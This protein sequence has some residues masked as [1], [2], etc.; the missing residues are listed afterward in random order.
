MTSRLS[1]RLL[2]TP[3]LPAPAFLVLMLLATVLTSAQLA[4]RTPI[5]AVALP[6]LEPRQ[7]LE[8]GSDFIPNHGQSDPL[9]RFDLRLH[10][11]RHTFATL[12][13]DLGV[14]EG[15]I[16]ALLGHVPSNITQHYARATLPAMREA[17]ELLEAHY[18]QGRPKAKG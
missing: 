13:G 6:S 12:L 3:L 15:V 8:R 11:L 7:T 2:P 4:V 17:V 5:P 10:D 16:G 14:A 9:V 1:Q 18:E